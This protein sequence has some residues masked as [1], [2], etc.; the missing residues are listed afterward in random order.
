M[1]R[2]L[3]TDSGQSKSQSYK[4]GNNKRLSNLV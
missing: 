4:R 3:R 2:S 1:D